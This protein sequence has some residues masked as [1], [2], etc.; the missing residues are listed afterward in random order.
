MDE[1]QRIIFVPVTVFFRAAR[2]EDGFLE[3][4]LLNRPQNFGDV[5]VIFYQERLDSKSL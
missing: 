2:N 1:V 3:E 5:F 4:L